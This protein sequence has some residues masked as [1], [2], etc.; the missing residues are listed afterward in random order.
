MVEDRLLRR[1]AQERQEA[2][3]E[4]PNIDRVVDGTGEETFCA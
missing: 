2:V 1:L 4:V 3:A